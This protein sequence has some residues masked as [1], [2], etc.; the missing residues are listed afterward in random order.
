MNL[1][2]A[3]PRQKS[4]TRISHLLTFFSMMLRGKLIKGPA[5]KEFE[6]EFS[7]KFN[8][9]FTL[10]CCSCRVAFSIIID[11]LNI[12]RGD[13]VILPAFN[14]SVFPKILLN[15]GIKP[16]FIDIKQNTLTI[17][18]QL[19]EKYITPKTKAIVAV[20]LFGKACDMD[21]ICTIARKYGLYVIEDCA[22]AYQGHYKND[23]LGT[24]GDVACFSL[25][26]TK[27]LPT[28]AGGVIL[29]ADQTIKELIVN[30]TDNILITPGI[31]LLF[32]ILVK[33]LVLK[34]TTSK[35]I[36]NLITYPFLLA[37]SHLNTD[38]VNVLFPTS[39]RNSEN[40]AHYQLSNFQAMLGLKEINGALNKVRKRINNSKL[41][42]A[43]VDTKIS[44][45]AIELELNSYWLYTL[46]SKDKKRFKKY[47]LRH[48]IDTK[49]FNDYNCN[50]LNSNRCNETSR[51]V[52]ENVSKR[53]ISIPNYYN[54]TDNEMGHILKTINEYAN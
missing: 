54:L 35:I 11:A 23:L 2:K 36:F 43:V 42:N 53:L 22:N 8:G 18:P 21:E 34:L 17:N 47:M 37:I 9:S 38:I 20:H 19:I 30:R 51:S 1:F 25:T 26:H 13:E 48:G 6:S 52:T 7:N 29:T 31:V 4:N 32:K 15:K 28:I 39:Y 45:Q 46:I 33:S 49:E 41:I 44:F 14:L 12:K 24:I 10:S 16:I 50:N 27:D 5:I 3:I 40:P